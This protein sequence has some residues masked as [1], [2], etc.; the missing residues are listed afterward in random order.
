MGQES[1]DALVGTLLPSLN[2]WKDFNVRISTPSSPGLTVISVAPGV[3]PLCALGLKSQVLSSE[4]GRTASSI[5]RESHPSFDGGLQ[6]PAWA[7]RGAGVPLDVPC[8]PKYLARRTTC[9]SSPIPCTRPRVS[10][11]Q[12]SHSSD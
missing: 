7:D 8:R 11:A 12:R 4:S 3:A 10:P 2:P 1:Q 6:S 9:G 5:A